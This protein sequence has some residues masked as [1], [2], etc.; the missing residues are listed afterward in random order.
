[1]PVSTMMMLPTNQPTIQP[2]NKP[3][4]QLT[5]K[6]TKK[7]A[8]QPTN[9]PTN[10]PTN[11]PINQQ[12]NQPTTQPMNWNFSEIMIIYIRNVVITVRFSEGPYGKSAIFDTRHCIMQW[13]Y[14]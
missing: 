12:T 6:P 1:M 5:N 13:L 2:T 14:S 3:T 7:P 4:H 11:Q 9:P 8:H 10:Q